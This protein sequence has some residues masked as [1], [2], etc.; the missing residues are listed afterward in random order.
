MGNEEF[1]YGI[2]KDGKLLVYWHGRHDKREIVLNGKRADRLAAGLPGM[3][4]ERE[5]LALAQI[6]GNFKLGNEWSGR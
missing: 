3:D 2:T 1:S 5:Q 6:T 4:R